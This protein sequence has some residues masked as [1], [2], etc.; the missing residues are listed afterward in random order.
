MSEEDKKYLREQLEL[1]IKLCVH[2]GYL[3]NWRS[4][5][6]ALVSNDDKISLTPF[7][8]EDIFQQIEKI[9][10]DANI[11]SNQLC[12]EMETFVDNYIATLR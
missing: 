1:V 6:E 7:Q 2:V 4:T 9:V 5:Y 8:K 12:R 11:P 10:C 3:S